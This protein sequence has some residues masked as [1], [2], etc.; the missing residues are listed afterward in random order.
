[1]ALT[2]GTGSL[3]P[4]ADQ[5]DPALIRETLVVTRRADGGAHVAPMGAR[6][7]VLADGAEGVLLQPFR[8]SATLDN[9]QRWPY[10]TL[11]HV[12]D[13]RI[14]AGCLTGRRDWPTCAAERIAGA[15][16]AAALAHEELEVERVE[17]DAE[18]PRFI[19]RLLGRTSHAPFPGF[20]R[21]KAA[22]LEAAIL[23]SRLHLLPAEK[24]ARELDYLRIAIDKTAG[25][26]EREAWQ[27]LMEAVAR[28]R[29][30]AR[31]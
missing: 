25:A 10:C 9:L 8:P 12:D 30:Q 1:M 14:F 21:A 27:W 16:L 17:E 5:L 29:Q 13:V 26:Q 28:H 7:V 15:R 3:L 20:N 18:R 22:V 2:Q 31:G 19:L 24:V 6:V 4:A 11:N 23:V